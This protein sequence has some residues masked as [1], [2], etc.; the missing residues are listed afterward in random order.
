MNGFFPFLNQIDTCASFSLHVG[1][2][3][4]F[5]SAHTL[6]I[7]FYLAGNCFGKFVCLANSN[8]RRVLHHQQQLS[9]TVF[10]LLEQQQHKT[11]GDTLNVSV[12]VCV[13]VIIEMWNVCKLAQMSDATV[14][15]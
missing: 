4:I 9:Q 12:C 10:E 1:V 14:N 7:Q 6:Q 2:T 3:F 15:V 5:P 13:A 11:Q 8:E